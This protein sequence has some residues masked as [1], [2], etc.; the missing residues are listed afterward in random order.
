MW[1]LLNLPHAVFV[2]LLVG[3]KMSQ[4]RQFAVFSASL[5]GT[6][7]HNANRC[8][9]ANQSQIKHDSVFYF[10]AN[11]LFLIRPCLFLEVTTGAVSFFTSC[12]RESNHLYRRRADSMQTVHNACCLCTISLRCSLVH[13]NCEQAVSLTKQL[14]VHTGHHCLILHQ[15]EFSCFFYLFIFIE[16]LAL[17]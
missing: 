7:E 6:E 10:C 16:G 9:Q 4:P 8:A 13:F 3:V 2:C 12:L 15:V 11:W 17:P 14:S 1:H 5:N